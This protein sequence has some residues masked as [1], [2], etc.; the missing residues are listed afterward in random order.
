MEDKIPRLE[1]FCCC[2]DIRS[3]ARNGAIF[4]I[5]WNVLYL[6][7]ALATSGSGTGSGIWSILF[8]IVN[9][10]AWVM[11]I[12]AF[13]KSNPKLLIP[14]MIVCVFDVVTSI[15]TAIIYFITIVLIPSG[16][17]ILIFAGLTAYFFVCLKN[18][19]DDMSSGTTDPAPAETK[20]QNPV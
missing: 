9:I 15:I 13:Q 16:I 19:Y 12:I 1:K 11:V 3:G 5:V 10:V 8:T 17:I 2:M 20:P 6:I 4:L 7:S 18:N 14:G